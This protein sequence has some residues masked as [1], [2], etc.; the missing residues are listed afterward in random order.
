[1]PKTTSPG[2]G[3]A[4]QQL[5]C[6]LNCSFTSLKK[7]NLIV[8]IVLSKIPAK[9]CAGLA[10]CTYPVLS[11]QISYIKL[12]NLL[13]SNNLVVGGEFTWPQLW[14]NRFALLEVCL[15]TPFFH[16][17]NSCCCTSWPHWGNKIMSWTA[18]NREVWLSFSNWNEP[19]KPDLYR[20]HVNLQKSLFVLDPVPL[21]ALQPLVALYEVHF[22]NNHVIISNHSY[23]E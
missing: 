14:H 15:Y 12:Y 16:F 23:K 13:F 17:H 21:L 18:C 3:F 8:L 1:M 22:Q 11:A 9:L 2:C 10:P 4:N 5:C 6:V 19:S 20:E 7:A